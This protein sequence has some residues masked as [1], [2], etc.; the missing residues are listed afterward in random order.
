VTDLVIDDDQRV[1]AVV[2]QIGGFL[3]MG[4]KPI[5]LEASDLRTDEQD[6]VR[7]GLSQPQLEKLPTIE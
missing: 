5:L 7:V 4:G 1:A 2:V 3:G 6:S